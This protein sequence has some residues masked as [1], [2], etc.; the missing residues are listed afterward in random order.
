MVDL[1]EGV[2]VDD[3]LVHDETN[4]AQAFLLADLPGAVAL[5]VLFRVEA[6]VYDESV[7]TQN[8]LALERFGA[9]DMRKELR[10]GH[11]WNVE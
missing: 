7:Q 10:K 1:G 2:S 11:T 6:P 4:L 8:R 9:P 5:G 3:L